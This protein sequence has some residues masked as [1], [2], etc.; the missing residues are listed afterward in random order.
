M[1]GNLATEEGSIVAAASVGR[2]ELLLTLLHHPWMLRLVDP[3]R[4][5]GDWILWV[6]GS[7]TSRMRGKS[8]VGWCQVVVEGSLCS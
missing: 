5:P 8:L 1:R 2:A 3:I 7:C 4:K 6:E